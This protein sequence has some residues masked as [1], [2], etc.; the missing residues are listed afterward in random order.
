[1]VSLEHAVMLL[2]NFVENYSVEVNKIYAAI[3]AHQNVNQYLKLILGSTSSLLN[4]TIKSEKK[5][6]VV[7]EKGIIHQWKQ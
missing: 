1:M 3:I 6:R 7:T 4:Y 2:S 5:I